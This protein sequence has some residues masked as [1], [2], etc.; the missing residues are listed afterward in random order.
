M[1]P[2]WNG[3][4]PLWNYAAGDKVLG[5]VKQTNDS[6]KPFVSILVKPDGEEMIMTPYSSLSRAKRDVE[7]TTKRMVPWT[8]R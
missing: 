2:R 5:R 3:Y 8:H 4:A 7:S 6:Q 1:T